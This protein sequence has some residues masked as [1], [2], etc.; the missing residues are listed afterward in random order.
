MQDRAYAAGIDLRLTGAAHS[1]SGRGLIG[2]RERL[3]VY[4][5][6]LHAGD[7]PTAGYRVYAVIP[8]ELP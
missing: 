5:G 7:L 3:A 2:M 4:G 8:L 6:S 1:G